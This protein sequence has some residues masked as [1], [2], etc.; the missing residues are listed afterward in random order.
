MKYVIIGASIA[1]LS[2]AR[3]I[4]EIEPDSQVV[5]LSK[6]S[7]KPYGKMTLPYLLSGKIYRNDIYLNVPEGAELLLNREVKAVN[8][9]DK[10]VTADTGEKIMYDKLLIATGAHAYIPEIPGSTLSSVLSVRNLSDVEKIKE[11]VEKSRE[12]TVILSG[13]GLV[14]MEIGD[15]LTEIGVPITYVVH[16]HRILSQIIDE[17]ASKLIEKELPKSHVRI[18]KGES[19]KE[20]EE[21]EN[22]VYAKLESGK[23]LKGSCIVFG[24]GVRPNISF[25]KDTGIKANLGILINDSLE[26]STK[27]IYA[28]GDVTEAKDI[29][30]SDKRMHALWPVAMEQGKIAGMNMTG[31]EIHYNGDV[32]RNILTVFGRTIFTGGIS[33]E[34]KFNV[35]KKDTDG[36]YRKIILKDGKLRGFVFIGEVENPGVYLHIMKN[37]VDIS[38]LKDPLLCGTITYADL[39]PSLRKVTL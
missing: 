23:V 10:F 32:S 39:H 8:T 38:T 20:I 22:I 27:D 21:G 7:E 2:A 12:K 16:S 15:A 36:E 28:A 14:N 6:E 17:E 25:L 29:V 3:K 18:L 11:K 26:T 13:A 34:D 5:V 31:K 33:R 30:Y 1:G 9:I 4:R 24:K 35:Y 19:I 37:E